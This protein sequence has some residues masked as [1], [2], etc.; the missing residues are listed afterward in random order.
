MSPRLDTDRTARRPQRRG[1]GPAPQPPGRGV[2]ARGHA[3]V[4]ATP[5]P[6]PPRSV[7]AADF[8]K[9]AHGHVF[10]ADPLALRRRRA[11]RPGHRGRR[12]A[13]GRP[14]RRHR[15]P[16][17]ARQPP[18]VAPRP[19]PTPARYA[20]IVEEH[21]LL[22]RLIGVAGEIAELGYAVPDDVQQGASTGPSR[23]SSRSPSAASPTRWRRSASLLDGQPRPPRAALRAGRRHHRHAHRLHRPRRAAV[24]P[25]AER[26]R[27]RRRPARHG[28]DRRSP[29]AWPPTPRSRRQPR[30]SLFFSLEMSH[31]ELTQR[32]LC[33]RG[34]GRLA[35]ACATASSAEPTGPRSA[36]PIGRLAEAPICIDDNP[37]L[38]VME[39]RAKARRLK[40]QRRRARP[41][42]RRLPPADDRPVAAPRTARSRCPR[43]AAASRS[44]PASSR[45]PV[46]ALSPAL[47][48]PRDAGRQAPDAGRPPRERVA[49]SR[50]PTS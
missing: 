17:R 21:A 9:P 18:G 14:A 50:T 41:D 26:P 39:I 23:W 40:S 27:H 30:R 1:P 13:P 11:G 10:D 49:S 8:Y 7:T 22:R 2:A 36:T 3:A 48:Q 37:N 12:A 38:T 32:L 42:R 16:G 5:S 45:R 20:R 33:V 28:Q 46:V 47:P 31:L 6:P 29:S 43:S 25:A 19:P 35:A 34:A 4:A 44:S 15:R 24:G